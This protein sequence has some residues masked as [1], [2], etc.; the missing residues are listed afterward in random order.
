ML[1]IFPFQLC[2][3][4]YDPHFLLRP[5]RS[6]FHNLAAARG[7]ARRCAEEAQ[8]AADPAIDPGGPLSGE[9]RSLS[10]RSGANLGVEDLHSGACWARGHFSVLRGRTTPVSSFPG[11]NTLPAPP[12]LPQ[13]IILSPKQAEPPNSANRD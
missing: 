13:I 3:H 4:Q 8:R 9:P 11:V 12:T 2:C 7:E 5:V 10:L 1:S 6:A